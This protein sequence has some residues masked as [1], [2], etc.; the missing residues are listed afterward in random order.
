MFFTKTLYCSKNVREPTSTD[1]PKNKLE[2]RL[3]IDSV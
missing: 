1:E 2:R 3:K